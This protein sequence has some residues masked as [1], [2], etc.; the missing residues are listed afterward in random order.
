ML[1]TKYMLISLLVIVLLCTGLSIKT[2]TLQA[3]EVTDYQESLSIV[4]IIDVSGS[5][6]YTDPMWLREMASQIFID[7]LLPGDYL[8]II[9]FDHEAQVVYPLQE[10]ET[11][12]QREDIKEAL[13]GRLAPRGATDFLEALETAHT[14]F[15][16]NDWQGSRP[17][18]VML[19]DGEP[20]PDSSRRDDEEFME[21][22]M[23]SLWK[24]VT[25]FA[26]DRY[27]IYTVGF[28]EEIDPQVMRKISMETKGEDYVLSDPGEI[29][30][31]FFKLLSTLRNRQNIVDY[32]FNLQEAPGQFNFMVDQNT[33]QVNLLVVNPLEGECEVSFQPP[34]GSIEG[35]QGL[36]TTRENRYMLI[37]LQQ[38]QEIHW[39]KW[40]VSITGSEQ[41]RVMGDLEPNVKAWMEGP[42]GLSQHPLH[43]PLNFKVRVARG[44]YSS[45]S[46][47]R[48]EVVLKRPG[49]FMPLTLPLQEVGDFFTGV[50]EQV[51]RAGDYEYEIRVLVGDELISTTTSRVSVQNLLV[52]TTDF[53]IEEG[54]HVGEEMVVTASLLMGG[55]RLQEGNDLRVDHFNLVLYY[56]DGER[57]TLPL[58]DS[59]HREHGDIKVSD[60]FWSNRLRF[61]R[62]GAVQAS[63]LAA[64]QY[65]GSDFML[66]KN[67]GSFHV[68]NPGTITI[69]LWDDNLWASPGGRVSIPL[70]IKNNSPFKE[71]LLVV[72]EQEMGTFSDPRIKLDPGEMKEI[73]LTFN[74]KEDI[75][76]GD[77]SLLLHFQVDDSLTW[78]E[79]SQLSLEVEVIT[80]REALMRRNLPLAYGSG[81]AVLIILGVLLF[82][83]LGGLILYGLLVYR[84]ARVGGSL[85]YFKKDAEDEVFSTPRKIRLKGRS[86]ERVV[87]TF[88]PEN[89]E[90]D[91][92][93]E[94]SKF[95]YDL[96]IEILR[97]K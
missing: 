58:Y 36:H 18:V 85:I 41:V 40:S 74:L 20:N 88:N 55:H 80:V 77:Y 92:Y 28:S 34:A 15:K 39:G 59:G 51:D 49:Q 2:E 7:L 63:L 21:A 65:R 10:I 37:N 4:L 68:Y 82:I 23:E 12:K 91:F 22:Y 64:G 46:P 54:Y 52:L 79:P 6:E 33:Q 44:Q 70:L 3:Q 17:V 61:L 14:Q 27:P 13:S 66:D 30:V 35:F 95:N 76:L 67:L 75:T 32:T 90:A 1:K 8:S 38:L 16:E 83:F 97:D 69:E 9:T 87:I 24:E 86:R 26:L 73:T 5:M 47:V 42:V 72:P 93:I 50:F 78:V 25:G 48:V 31:T 96:I 89:Q 84:Q 56:E 94:G 29:A 81:K 62:E 60:G 71:T 53:W 57:V 11:P 43:E 45:Q 19:T